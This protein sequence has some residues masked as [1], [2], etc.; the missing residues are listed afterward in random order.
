MV[1]NGSTR[2]ELVQRA[3]TFALFAALKAHNNH[4]KLNLAGMRW[5][6]PPPKRDIRDLHQFSFFSYEKWT[7][8]SAPAPLRRPYLPCRSWRCEL[9]TRRMAKYVLGPPTV[10]FM[11]LILG[12]TDFTQD[13]LLNEMMEDSQMLGGS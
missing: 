5:P 3:T 7:K 8:M 10:V 12:G 13:I 4:I 1:P 11:W 6:N 9:G 2:V